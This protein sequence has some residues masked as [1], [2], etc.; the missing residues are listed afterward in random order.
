[1]EGEKVL[2]PKLMGALCIIILFLLITEMRFSFTCVS[3][4]ERVATF[5]WLYTWEGILYY[6]TPPSYDTS[7]GVGLNMY[8]VK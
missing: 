8:E 5:L 1:M 3:S 4:W 6:S 2:F 7:L